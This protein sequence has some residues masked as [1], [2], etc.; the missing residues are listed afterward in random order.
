MQVGYTGRKL[1]DRTLGTSWDA[2]ALEMAELVRLAPGLAASGMEACMF[3]GFA[4]PVSCWMA[5]I[6]GCCVEEV[7]RREE[8]E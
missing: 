1:A 8:L 7:A 5:E 6:D 4:C 2:V 3:L